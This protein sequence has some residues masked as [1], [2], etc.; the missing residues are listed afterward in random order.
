MMGTVE[1]SIYHF[2]IKDYLK[3]NVSRWKY[4]KTH[5]NRGK[6]PF[7]SHFRGFSL[8]SVRNFQPADWSYVSNS[9]SR[10]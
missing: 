6:G 10:G 3:E 2:L 5:V 4:V 9:L 1:M 7:Q 8:W